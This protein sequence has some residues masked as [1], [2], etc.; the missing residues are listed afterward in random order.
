VLKKKKREGSKMRKKPNWILGCIILLLPA[1]FVMKYTAE[2]YPFYGEDVAVLKIAFQHT[3][4][5]VIE[6]DEIGSLK[7]KA[8]AYRKEMKTSGNVKMNLKSKQSSTRERFPV[9][10]ELYLN[11]E[12]I[13]SRE[14]QPSG[15]QRDAVSVI[16][17]TFELK[18][19]K[20]DIKMVMVD[21]K[22]EPVIPFTFED[23]VEFKS[24]EVKLITF[25][26]VKKT[27]HWSENLTP[28]STRE[29]N[30]HVEKRTVR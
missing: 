28:I 12:N 24:R 15:R 18:P 30:Q 17:D 5:R 7:A 4:Q 3:G 8:K 21:T 26:H 11:G 13:L 20:Y 22:R 16:Y 23:S 10:I 19:G 6:Y 14:Y 25:D 1:L 29:G 9:E 2:P 27:L